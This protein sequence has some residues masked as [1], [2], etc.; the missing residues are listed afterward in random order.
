[1]EPG[2]VPG[3]SRGIALPHNHL[4]VGYTDY[5]ARVAEGQSRVI[6]QALG[7]MKKHPDFRYTLDGSWNLEQYLLTRDPAGQQEALERVREGRLGLPAQYAN[8]LTGYASLETLLRS[9]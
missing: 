4:D 7:L 8:L 3:R 9:L 1:M 2:A 5:P 6:D